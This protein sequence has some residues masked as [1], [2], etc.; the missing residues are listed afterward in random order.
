MALAFSLASASAQQLPTIELHVSTNT[1][2]HK[3]IAEV[4]DDDAERSK[5]LMHRTELGADRGMLFWHN[6]PRHITMWMKDT[7]L[8]LDMIFLNNDGV[9]HSIVT[10]TVPYSLDYIYS[11]GEVIGVLEVNAGTVQ[12]IGLKPGDRITRK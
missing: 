10:N 12:R 8:S 1:G 5:G 4:A 11:G 3:F 2:V 7:P 6:S 9:V